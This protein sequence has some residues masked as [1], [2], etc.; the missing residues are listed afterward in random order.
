MWYVYIWANVY[1][2]YIC[3]YAHV[4]VPLQEKTGVT[5]VRV[6]FKTIPFRF[7]PQV[8]L[9][10]SREP[11]SGGTIEP[12]KCGSHVSAGRITGRQEN[13]NKDLY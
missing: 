7:F 11:H 9:P 6:F 2:M 5:F 10:T 8:W 3:V 1:S 13:V 12:H 4:F